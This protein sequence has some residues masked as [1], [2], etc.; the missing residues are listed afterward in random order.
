MEENKFQSQYSALIEAKRLEDFSHDKN[1]LPVY[2]SS[3]AKI[4]PY[5]IAAA[6]FALRSD[7]LKGCILCDEGSL[8]KT[9]EALLV[10][11]QKWYEGKEN[12]L[13]VLPPNLVPQW[14]RKLDTDFTLPNVFWNNTK[15]IPDEDGIVI[16]TYENASKR[17]D[18]IKERDW[19]LV[20]FDEAD[21]LSKPEKE[22][23]KTLKSAVR[24]AYKLL[25]TP[26]PITLSIMDI[27][28]LIHFIDESILP[29][30][31]CFYKRYFRKPENYPELTSWVS[32]FCFRTLKS[33][34]TEYVNFSRRLPITVDYPLLQEEKE[35][36]KLISTYIASENKA[37][38]PEMDE[39][40]LNLLFFKTL[41]SSPQAFSNMLDNPIT[42]AYGMENIILKQM[43]DLAD[44]I[45]INSKTLRLIKILRTV[46]NHL[47]VMKVNQK[48]IIFVS[49]S[50]T[51]DVLYKLFL[52]D[53]YNTIKYKDNNSLERFRADADI[54]ILIATDD[55]AKGLD[56]EYCPVVVNYD[57]IYNSIQMEQRICRCH[58]QGQNSD[59]LVINLLSHENFADVRMLKLINKRTLQFNGIFGMS[60]DIVGNFDT[61]IK[62]VLKDFRHRDEVAQAF[63]E[64]LTEHRQANE[65]LVENSED[66]LFTTFTKSIADKVAVTPAYI[67][68]KAAELNAELWELVKYYFETI[69]PDW[70]EIDDENK[71]LTLIEGYKRPYLFSFNDNGRMRNYE[72]YKRYGLGKDFKPQTGRISFTS[73]FAKG[74]LREIDTNIAPEAK[75][76]INADIEP[77][78]IGFYNVAIT[79]KDVSSTRH[80]L[81]GQTQS[82][83][84]LTEQKCRELLSLPVIEI[85][86][87]T[88]LEKIRLCSLL[89]D[90][91]NL[92][93]KISKDEIIKEYI[94]SQEGSFAFEVEKIKLLAG[95][96]K[97]QLE[98]HLN[99]IKT[100][101]KDLKKQACA[102]K[103]EELKTTKRV[104]VLE[105][106]LLKREEKLFYDKAQIDVET[107]KEIADLTDEYNFN[108]LVSPHF[109]VQIFSTNKEKQDEPELEELIL[110]DPNSR[111]C[112]KPQW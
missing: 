22:I 108:V 79:S 110:E 91:G 94:K 21:T 13:V 55:A 74:I 5:Q 66:I 11:G 8:G 33:Q 46:F 57:M 41:S 78:E 101:I 92:D 14:K 16:T 73:T 23:V 42:R 103:L 40:N 60:D 7:F 48:A 89:E 25:L 6:R 58:R 27:Y 51:L 68:E 64:N 82:G 17:A 37:A 99:D 80:I 24:E 50:T 102:N 49:N 67:E 93:E 4:L 81:I 88:N 106:E 98:T 26:T 61:K 39:Y 87:R 1:F 38:Y 76:Y 77:C 90:F 75:I 59:V 2:A 3:T 45:K 65:Q 18:K 56:I 95:R 53:G 111:Y 96:K 20:I 36:Y 31:D 54:Q 85:E 84:I 32:Q 83:E 63:K 30:A 12:I 43:K 10:A 29:D 52:Q 86:E 72:G 70:Y 28:G 15:N 44:N 9:Y 109:K 112:I 104:K 100:D 47:K 35:L 34:T 105:K 62:E 97:T 69:K 19:D 107:E 71:T